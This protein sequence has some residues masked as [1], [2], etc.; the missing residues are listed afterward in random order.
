MIE[1]QIFA[2]LMGAFGERI[3]K[4]L[5]ADA[6]AMYSAIL[7]AE[8]TTEEFQAAMQH[9]FRNHEWNTWPSPKQI[10]ESVK[11]ND[12]LKAATAWDALDLEMRC[13]SHLPTAEVM[14]ALDARLEDKVALQTFAALGG[15]RRFRA[16][17]T[18]YLKS[19]MRREF[20][21]EYGHVQRLPAPER[22]AVLPGFRPAD[23][24]P[25]A[26]NLPPVR[27]LPKGPQP[28]SA[29]VAPYSPGDPEQ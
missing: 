5:S 14:Q 2:R 15:P 29:L 13:L 28:L 10:I 12:E 25:K 9:V 23:Q 26:P 6:L 16:A 8:L 11:P 27:Q 22:D 24:M 18:E 21:R 17:T 20:L 1:P 4:A 19:E 7:S 3:G